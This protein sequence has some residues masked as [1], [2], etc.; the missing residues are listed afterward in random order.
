MSSEKKKQKSFSGA[1]ADVHD[2]NA[3]ALSMTNSE[4]VRAADIETAQ[5]R[6]AA[7]AA[8]DPLVPTTIG[9]TVETAERSG[10]ATRPLLVP[11]TWGHAP[12]VAS[13]NENG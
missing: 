8:M 9:G 6:N 5:S 1:R 2:S 3:G 4:T 12:V 7:D 13:Q 11:E 10:G